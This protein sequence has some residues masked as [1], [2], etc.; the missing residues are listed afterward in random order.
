MNLQEMMKPVVE[1]LESGG[2]FEAGGPGASYRVRY[3]ADDGRYL[4][5]GEGT[6]GPMTGTA[7]VGLGELLHTMEN[8][9]PLSAWE[10]KE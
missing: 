4:V 10:A 7:P 8:H 3:L 9:A 2:T 1:H 5:M 6:L